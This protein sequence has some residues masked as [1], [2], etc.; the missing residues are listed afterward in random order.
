MKYFPQQNLL[1]NN[2]SKHETFEG[3]I[4]KLNNGYIKSKIFIEVNRKYDVLNN[5]IRKEV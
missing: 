3:K 4:H 5:F 1:N 2:N